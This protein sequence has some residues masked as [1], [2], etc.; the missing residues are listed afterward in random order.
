MVDINKKKDKSKDKP[1]K[2]KD[3]EKVKESKTKK[4]SGGDG[5]SSSNTEPY[6]MTDDKT[7]NAEGA[8]VSS[9]S[10]R[11]S[12]EGAELNYDA[13]SGGSEQEYIKR[14]IK[15]CKEFYDDYTETALDNI[16]D[17]NQ[18]TLYHH[19]LLLSMAKNRAGI[20]DIFMKRFGYSEDEALAKARQVCKKAGEPEAFV[21]LTDEV[22]VSIRED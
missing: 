12:Q 10:K 16:T 17:I 2:K 6:T 5:G 20:C 21:K 15:E 1:D 3:K 7:A 22:T 13:G 19:A 18:F 9:T 8:S 14:Q 11:W 4:Q